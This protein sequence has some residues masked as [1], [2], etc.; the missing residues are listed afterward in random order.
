MGHQLR[1][2]L[3]L[4]A[5]GVRLL[6]R[7]TALAAVSLAAWLVSAPLTAYYFGFFSAYS[8][9]A[10]LLVVPISSLVMLLASLSLL[11]GSLSLPLN[12]LCNQ[13]VWLAT[14][15]MRSIAV[16]IASWPCAAVRV[17]IPLGGVILWHGVVWSLAGHEARR[18]ARRAGDATWLAQARAPQASLV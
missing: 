1:H 7:I 11:L 5:V 18:H 15:L 16:G 12:I 17:T 13:T 10:N 2:Q 3:D 9:L 14:A 8:L 6:E 4:R